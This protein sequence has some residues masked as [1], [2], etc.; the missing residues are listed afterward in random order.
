MRFKI[1][2]DLSGRYLNFNYTT[3]RTEIFN[4]EPEIK[5]PIQG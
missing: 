3:L 4:V 5:I 1:K 2:N